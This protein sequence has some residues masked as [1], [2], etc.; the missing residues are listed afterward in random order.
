MEYHNYNYFKNSIINNYNY[1]IDELDKYFNF[2]ESISKELYFVI[3]II[4]K[5]NSESILPIKITS[6]SDS[7]IVLIF[8]NFVIKLF[9]FESIF[10]KEISIIENCKNNQN[11]VNS[12]GYFSTNNGKINKNN[13]VNISEKLNLDNR[14]IFISI[15]EKLE[16]LTELNNNKINLLIDINNIHI[17]LKLFLEI[18]S[19]LEELHNN[20]IVHG[21][22]RLDNIGYKDNKFVLFD[23]NASN[24]ENKNYLCDII[25]LIKSVKFYINNID[26]Y[27][28]KDFLNF[29]KLS[30]NG[31]ILINNILTFYREY[32]GYKSDNEIINIIKSID[33]SKFL[34]HP[35]KFKTPDSPI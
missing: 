22:C 13:I 14:N 2:S 18:G 28:I 31:D 12:L 20:G 27:I 30:Q 10:D 4:E 26:D 33:I 34:L 17:L 25:T 23:F 21:D 15:T 7:L 6:S 16:L 1:D 29:I 3:K 9:Q 5:L 35:W 32:F 11:I 24:F 8:S 19:A